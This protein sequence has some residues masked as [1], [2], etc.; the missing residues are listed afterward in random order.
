MGVKATGESMNREFT[1]ENGEVIVS[2]SANVGVNTIGTMTFTLLDA[3]K[4]KDSETI[5][6]DLKTFIDDVLAMSAKY[7]N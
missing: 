5:A 7:L 6:E 1:N 3:Q 4:I 2:S